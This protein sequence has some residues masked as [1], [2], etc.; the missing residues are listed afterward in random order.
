MK[1]DSAR[2]DDTK[3]C[4]FHKDHGHQ[5]DDCIQLKKEIEYLIRCGH[6]SRYMA[7]EG[8]EQVQ[9]PPSRQPNPVQHQPPLG[10]IHVISGGFAGGGESSLAK[11]GHLR[12]IR[13][14]ET[15]EVETVSKLPRL[16][17]TITF[18]DFDME[19]C[20]HPHDDPLVIKTIVANRTIHRVLVDNGSSAGIIFTSAFDKMG[21]G[22]EKL[23]PVNACLRGFSGERVLPSGSVQ[24]VLTL[25]DPL[26]QA[27]TT[28]RFLIV[29]A[30]SAYNMLLGRP[31]LNAIRVVPSAYHMV[32]K[33]PTANGVRMV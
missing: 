21:I 28:M 29:D 20:Q 3:Y 12:S 7:L 10:E 18:S 4:E 22:R 15:L 9:P 24:L 32:I 5:R 27:T 25:G 13:S 31:S 6:L 30:P 11:K 2:R 19:G 8:R 26:C 14:G 17:T 1:S 23:E 33:F 16:D